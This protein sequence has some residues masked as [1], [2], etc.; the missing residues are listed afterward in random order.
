M[1]YGSKKKNIKKKD[2]K[3]GQEIRRVHEL[4]HDMKQNKQPSPALKPRQKLCFS[5]EQF[6][7]Q[8]RDPWLVLEGSGV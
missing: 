8:P 3:C 2:G 6:T 4:Q 7:Q 5:V 1:G